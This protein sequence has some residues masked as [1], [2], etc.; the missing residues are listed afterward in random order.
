M[1]IRSNPPLHVVG[2]IA[3]RRGDPDRGPMVAIR[4]DDA[5]ARLIYEGELVYLT[6]PRRKEMVVVRY[7]D[8]LPRGAAVV[9]DVSGIA[10][11]EVVRLEKRDPPR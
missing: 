2:F 8:T 1:T 6:G 5:A 10:A 9:R 3:T 7:D 11:S 4:P